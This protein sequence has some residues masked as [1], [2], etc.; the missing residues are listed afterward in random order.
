MLATR[1][2]INK[3]VFQLQVVTKMKGS[4]HHNQ[5]P[6]NGKRKRAESDELQPGRKCGVAVSIVTTLCWRRKNEQRDG[7]RLM[8]DIPSRLVEEW[9]LI[10]RAKMMGDLEAN[11]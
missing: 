2:K 3:T 8:S 4:N 10:R 9:R 11:D 6:T 5:D 7:L 1:A